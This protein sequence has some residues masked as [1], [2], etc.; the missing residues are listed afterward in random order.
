MANQTTPR[1][2]LP[3]AVDG[4]SQRAVAA[5]R[6]LE[7]ILGR[8][9]GRVEY[10]APSLGDRVA[11]TSDTTINSTT[12]TDIIGATVTFTPEV[13]GKVEI[14]ASCCTFVSGFGA[15]TDRIIIYLAVNGVTNA[16]N[17]RD[18]NF[19]AAGQRCTT[20]QS[21]VVAVTAG[22][23]YTIKLRAGLTVGATSTYLVVATASGFTWKLFPAAYRYPAT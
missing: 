20:A 10:P 7:S 15:A 21:W 16:V 19:S 2:R 5:L 13:S 3:A 18:G 1:W 11:C 4:L 12:A 9:H 23:A 22:T 8:L 6:S 17:A 14:S